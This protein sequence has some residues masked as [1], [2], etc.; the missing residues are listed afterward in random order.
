MG[1]MER[2]ACLCTN[3]ST[4]N[5]VAVSC[6]QAA[7]LKMQVKTSCIKC[8]WYKISCF[9]FVGQK[10]TLFVLQYSLSAKQLDSS[11][12]SDR[13]TA[14]DETLNFI[15]AL[16]QKRWHLSPIL[17]EKI[18]TLSGTSGPGGKSRWWCSLHCRSAAC[19][20]ACWSDPTELK[21]SNYTADGISSK[22]VQATAVLVGHQTKRVQ[23]HFGSNPKP[24]SLCIKVGG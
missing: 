22:K 5:L 21:W 20:F 11:F 23:M 14:T 19:N 10:F 24:R 15:S 12:M 13:N 3:M 7:L 1:Q 6:P 16:N 2:I 9:H 18:Q 17:M 8:S 4:E